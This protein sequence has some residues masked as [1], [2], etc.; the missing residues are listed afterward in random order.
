MK[1]WN[2]MT[3][4]ELELI[5]LTNQKYKA[6][7]IMQGRAYKKV[8][9]LCKECISDLEKTKLI[10]ENMAVIDIKIIAELEKMKRQNKIFI[11]PCK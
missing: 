3:N 1:G 11:E 5:D 7:L 4:E 2:D 6:L 8:L 10:D 9:S